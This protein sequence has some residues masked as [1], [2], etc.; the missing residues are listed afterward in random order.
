M[1]AY[2]EDE[3]PDLVKGYNLGSIIIIGNNIVFYCILLYCIV[4]YCKGEK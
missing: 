3:K 4:L 2:F 1:R